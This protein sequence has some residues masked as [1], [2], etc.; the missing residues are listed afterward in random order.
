M[1][2]RAEKMDSQYGAAPG[3]VIVVVLVFGHIVLWF[4]TIGVFLGY[5]CGVS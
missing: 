1:I 4:V 3:T 5:A 2:T